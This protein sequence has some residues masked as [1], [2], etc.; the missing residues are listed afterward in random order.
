[1]KDFQYF[2]AQRKANCMGTGGVTVRLG[3]KKEEE[4]QKNERD[5]R[6]LYYWQW[7]YLLRELEQAFLCLFVSPKDVSLKLLHGLFD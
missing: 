5:V 2:R 3:M 4:E 1:M 7:R 6:Y